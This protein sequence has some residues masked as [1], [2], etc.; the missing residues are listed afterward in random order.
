L[1]KIKYEASKLEPSSLL[2]PVKARDLLEYDGEKF[3]DMLYRR[4]LGR[5]PDPAGKADYL[6]VARKLPKPLI[7]YLFSR[8]YEAKE[9]GTEIIGLHSTL[10]WFCLKT[11]SALMKVLFSVMKEPFLRAC[12]LL[13]FRKAAQES[14]VDYSKFYV[15]FE[16]KF[17]GPEQDVERGLMIY[18]SLL[19]STSGLVIDLGSGR[20]EW[21][22]LLR[23]EGFN[24]K[25]VEINPYFIEGCEEQGLEVV[26][27]D[28]FRFLKKAGSSSIG[29]ITAFHL[30][31]HLDPR[32]R[33]LFLKEICRV[34]KPGGVLILETPN[35]RNILVSA[36]DFWRDTE[37]TTPVFPDT[38]SFMAEFVGF[39]EAKCYFFN[40]S[41][42]ALIACL[43]IDFRD[44]K[45]YIEV[46]RDFALFARKSCG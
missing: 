33:L 38:L 7:I 15:D 10:I 43:D 24:T 20:G 9:K 4:V 2:A 18:L 27:S 42:T 40:E 11:P 31:E 5:E 44:L 23:Q 34:L 17:R 16:E 12:S 25:G 19:Q 45:D 13:S 8:S 39:S 21:L 35:P 41:R 14:S 37:H 46:S 32:Q 6:S 22:R 28:A 30:I 26:K 1:L 36:G 29:A 3:I